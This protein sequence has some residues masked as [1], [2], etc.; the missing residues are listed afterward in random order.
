[1]NIL[2]SIEHFTDSSVNAQL[3]FTK[4][5]QHIIEQHRDEYR[6]ISYDPTDDSSEHH[7]K[8]CSRQ[9]YMSVEHIM[10]FVVYL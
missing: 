1:M 9:V 5:L 3:L 10:N 7:A 2:T 8:L 4:P 6:Y